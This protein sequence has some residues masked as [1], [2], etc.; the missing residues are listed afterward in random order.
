M[1]NEE[2]RTYLG[3]I[4]AAALIITVNI[5]YIYGNPVTSFRYAIFQVASIITTTGFATANYVE[6][7]MLSQTVL[8][9]LMV[10]GACASSTGGGIKVSRLIMAVKGIKRE[11]MQLLHPKSVNIIRVNGKKVSGDVVRVVFVFLAAYALIFMLSVIVVSADNFDFTTTFSAVLTT[12]G[13]V[14]PGMELVGPLGS[15][16]EFSPLS[17]LVFCF[18]MLAGRLEIFPFLLLFTVPFRRNKF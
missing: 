10:V 5:N 9:F 15:F 16:A 8:M 17:K 18:D 13:N 2:L 7:P 14:G 11:V 6:W 3:I 12:I 4:L 1:E